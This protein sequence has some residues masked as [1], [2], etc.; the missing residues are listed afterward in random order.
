MYIFLFFILLT[1][2]AAYMFTLAVYS[3]TF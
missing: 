3:V 1:A 2:G